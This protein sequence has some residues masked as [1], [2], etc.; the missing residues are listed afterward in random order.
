[1]Y[2]IGEKYY[3]RYTRGWQCL[4]ELLEIDEKNNLYLMYN[5]RHGVF[6]TT[7]EDLDEKN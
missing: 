5:K 3:A 7:K 2:I 6:Y 4:A 1:M